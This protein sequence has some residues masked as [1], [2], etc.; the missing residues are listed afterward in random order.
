M[1]YDCK[2]ISQAVGVLNLTQGHLVDSYIEDENQNGEFE[3][4]VYLLKGLPFT[5]ALL[6]RVGYAGKSV[7]QHLQALVTYDFHENDEDYHDVIHDISIKSGLNE[8]DLTECFSFLCAKDNL[9][10]LQ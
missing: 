3:F 6:Q 8:Y 2:Q 10:H 4:P 7:L 5:L 9:S 1:K